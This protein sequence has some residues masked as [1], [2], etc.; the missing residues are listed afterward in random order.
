[1]KSNRKKEISLTVPILLPPSINPDKHEDL[2]SWQ[3]L[4]TTVLLSFKPFRFSS[5][6]LQTSKFSIFFMFIFT[7]RMTQENRNKIE[8]KLHLSKVESLPIRFMIEFPDIGLLCPVKEVSIKNP[9]KQITRNLLNIVIEIFNKKSRIP[10]QS[11]ASTDWESSAS[12]TFWTV[13]D[14]IEHRSIFK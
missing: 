3:R 6:N 13:L 1:M 9:T 11:C 2:T 7:G 8:K 14:V 12:A 4:S 10:K 5:E